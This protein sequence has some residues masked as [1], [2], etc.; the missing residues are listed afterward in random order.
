MTKYMNSPVDLALLELVHHNV[1]SLENEVK[2]W[3]EELKEENEKV[4]QQ[5]QKFDLA[6]EEINQRL[7]R[8]EASHQR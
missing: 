2:N 5:L 3:S 6:F 1:H 7:L 4:Q 8:L